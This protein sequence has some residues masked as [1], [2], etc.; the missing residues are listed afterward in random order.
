MELMNLARMTLYEHAISC[1]ICVCAGMYICD[2]MPLWA[3]T[4]D[5]LLDFILSTFLS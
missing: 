4:A 1:S 3:R 2:H 5:V